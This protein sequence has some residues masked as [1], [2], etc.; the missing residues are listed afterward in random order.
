MLTVDAIDYEGRTD[1]HHQGFYLATYT[2]TINYPSPDGRATAYEYGARAWVKDGYKVLARYERGCSS[3]D[4]VDILQE[5]GREAETWVRVL[6]AHAQLRGMRIQAN[7]TRRQIADAELLM[8]DAYR[9]PELREQLARQTRDER[10]TLLTMY[11][12][13]EG[14][15]RPLSRWW[16]EP[17]A[18]R[19]ETPMAAGL[20]RD[21]LDAYQLI[22]ERRDALLT[23]A[24][25]SQLTK[26]E[27]SQRSGIARTTIDRALAG[28][29]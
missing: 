15:D 14:L 8:E 19:G 7:K 20:A 24:V 5:A 28:H 4:A 10:R 2:G 25:D 1:E 16:L 23:L 6:V 18:D 21:L 9:V 29:R 26:A 13:A 22:V 3:A 27:I 12:L 17:G 11:A